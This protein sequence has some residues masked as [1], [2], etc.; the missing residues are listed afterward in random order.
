MKV[1]SKYVNHVEKIEIEDIMYK[2]KYNDP[3]NL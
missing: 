1:M 2:L 3:Y